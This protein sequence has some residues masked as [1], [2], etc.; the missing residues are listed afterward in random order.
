MTPSEDGRGKDFVLNNSY[1]ET[2]SM[3]PVEDGYYGSGGTSN[4]QPPEP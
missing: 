3:E 2:E 1:R 4:G